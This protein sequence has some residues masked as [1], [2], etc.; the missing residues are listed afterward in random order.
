MTI[1]SKIN[2][3]LRTITDIKLSPMKIFEESK[4][5]HT[6]VYVLNK[7]KKVGVMLDV[8]EFH[9]M[10][11]MVALANQFIDEL[12]EERY[13]EKIYHRIQK[14]KNVRWTDEEVRNERTNLDL[15]SLP[16]EWE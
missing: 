6:A 4:K 9:K 1:I 15:S 3:P 8:E 13:Q 2:V 16:D 11:E 12:A 5:K 14:D 7:N 10:I